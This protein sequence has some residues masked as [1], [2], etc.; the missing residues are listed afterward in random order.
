MG[1]AKAAQSTREAATRAAG[2]VL[3][4]PFRPGRTDATA[5][6]TDAGSFAAL[7]PGSDGFRNCHLASAGASPERL[8]LDRA[9]QL[10]LPAP[11]LTVLLGGLRVLGAHAGGSAQGLFTQRPG[12][13]TPDFLVELLDMSTVWTPAGDTADEGRDRCSGTLCRTAS[14]VALMVG[15]HAQLRAI[16]EVYAQHDNAATFVRDFGAAWTNVM[17]LD[18]FD[19]GRSFRSLPDAAGACR[20]RFVACAWRRAAGDRN[21]AVIDP[22]PSGVSAP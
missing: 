7:E 5:E 13:P 1:R 2:H 9:Q 21:I 11:E 10:T 22:P 19:R 6:M 15:S 4:L 8:L 20:L 17:E 16:A 18:R 3:K 14:R 12:Q